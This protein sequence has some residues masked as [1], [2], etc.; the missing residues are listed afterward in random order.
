MSS[1]LLL[2]VATLAAVPRP[3]S[4]LEQ[5]AE[6][7]D[8]AAVAQDWAK[9]LALEEKGGQALGAK[10]LV[11]PSHVH[12]AATTVL[13]EAKAATERRD[14]LATRRAANQPAAAVVEFYEPLHPTLPTSVMRLDVLLRQLDLAAVAGQAN[15]ARAALEATTRVWKPLRTSAP[16]VGTPAAANFYHAPDAV[17]RAVDAGDLQATARDAVAALEDVDGL[18]RL[19]AAGVAR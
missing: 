7:I 18:E 15:G 4:V 14:V 17:R 10:A 9:V 13:V 6:E 1:A 2:A 8:D 16:V 11:K 5:T 19:Y 12:A 3:L